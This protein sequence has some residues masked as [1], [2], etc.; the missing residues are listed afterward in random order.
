MPAHYCGQ[1]GL[2]QTHGSVSL[3]GCMPTGTGHTDHIGVH[4]RNVGDAR[5]MLAVMAGYDPLDAHSSSKPLVP[6]E[7]PVEPHTL[8][9]GVP[10]D[11]FW[12][13][14]DPGVDA[15]CRAALLA[16][17][18]AG[19][20]LVEVPVTTAGLI[21]L[22]RAAGMAEGFVYHQPY[23]EARPQDY[24]ADIRYRLMAGE[25]VLAHD[26]I[27]AMRVRRLVQQDMT[28]LLDT[29]D[30]LAVPTVPVPAFPIP[31]LS[32]EAAPPDVM[33]TIQNTMVFN[34][35][36]HPAISIPAGF[37][38]AGLPVG[39]MLAATA[40]DDYRLLATAEAFEQVLAVPVVPPILQR[41]EVGA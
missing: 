40:F 28:A 27:R 39:L 8:C 29:V 1:V 16:M 34:Q 41:A 14:I 26:Y 3:K 5:E 9:I 31:S 10:R 36:G 33:V 37:T 35:T 38:P 12:D 15:V 11:Y 25:F 24:G 17:E 2:K 22:A 6:F 19:A 20:T 18:R 21:P 7:G 4:A 13:N 32:P 23:L 30:V